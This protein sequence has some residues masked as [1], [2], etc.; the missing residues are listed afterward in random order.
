MTKAGRLLASSLLLGTALRVVGLGVES[1]W[2]DEAFTA[3]RA[4][5]TYADLFFDTGSG[6]QV[7]LYFWISKAWCGIAGTGEAALRFPAFVFGILLIPMAFLLGRELFEERAARWG[8][9]FAAI[10]PVLIH[11]SQ[12]A[13]PYSLYLLLV[14]CSWFYLIRWIRGGER[15]HFLGWYLSTVG[16]LYTHPLGVLVLLSH[17]AGFL[18]FPRVIGKEGK[19]PRFKVFLGSMFLV[20]VPYLPLLFRM[21]EQIALK[22]TGGSVAD[23]IDTPGLFDLLYTPVWYFARIAVA[24]LVALSLLLALAVRPPPSEKNRWA[25]LFLATVWLTFSLLP[26]AV[27]LLITPLYVFRYTLPVLAALLL[28]LGWAMTRLGPLIRTSAVV[29][30][31]AASAGPLYDFHTGLDKPPWRDAGRFLL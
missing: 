19:E 27:S 14:V 31:L 24:G 28:L 16:V 9:F 10:N 5:L 12:D 4:P 6:S 21:E 2:L 15:R 18:L 22:M 11:Y 29:L 7:P 30:F 3:R 13:R 20:L 26:W 17:L 1:L 8:A 25:I 23:W